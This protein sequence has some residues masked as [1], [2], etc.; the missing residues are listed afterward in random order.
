M[1]RRH[2]RRSRPRP[3]VSP[4]AAWGRQRPWARLGGGGCRAAA[5]TG[6][7]FRVR[8]P[9]GAGCSPLPAAPARG[10]R[11]RGRAGPHE[12]MNGGGGAARGPASPRSQ[13]V[14]LR[15]AAAAPIGSP[16]PGHLHAARPLAEPLPRPPRLRFTCAA[17]LP[18]LGAGRPHPP[19]A[20][21]APRPDR[22]ARPAA[23]TRPPG[24]TWPCTR[25]LR[26]VNRLEPSVAWIRW[27]EDNNLDRSVCVCARVRVLAVLHC[28]TC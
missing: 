8:P 25:R 11:G 9:P 4:G 15:S 16:A 19:P 18:A 26:R 14:P 6:L 24:R 10:P 3:C 27:K 22:A 2:G 21:L 13:P 12:R 17:E 1:G 5:A 7:R 20:S 28:N 23:P